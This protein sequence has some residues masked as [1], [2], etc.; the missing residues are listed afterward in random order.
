[1][2]VYLNGKFIPDSEATIPVTDRGFIF[3]D[4]V[5]EV[6]RVIDGRLFREKEH[7]DR[8]KEGLAGLQINVKPDQL[9]SL[10]KNMQDRKSTRLNS[11]HVA[12]SYAVFC[13][14]KK[15]EDDRGHTE[16]S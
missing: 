5:Y 9:Q 7:L 16:I 13:L 6:I 14:K 1:M 2:Q 10:S 4:G 15:T 11:S 8:L 12:I 3:G